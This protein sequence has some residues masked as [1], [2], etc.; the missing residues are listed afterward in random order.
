[1]IKKTVNGVTC[2]FADSIDEVPTEDD[3]NH[4]YINTKILP[5]GISV[6]D[7]DDII[8]R[9]RDYIRSFVDQ[10]LDGDRLIEYRFGIRFSD[11]T[12]VRIYGH[13]TISDIK[14]ELIDLLLKKLNSLN[15][16]EYQNSK[17]SYE[18]L[19][20]HI[21]KAVKTGDLME[22][23]GQIAERLMDRHD[24]EFANNEKNQ[25]EDLKEMV[26]DIIQS[27]A[28]ESLVLGS[29]N[30]VSNWK[31]SLSD[32]DSLEI[33]LYVNNIYNAKDNY[34]GLLK[35]Y[36]AVIAHEMFHY[37]HFCKTEI[38]SYEYYDHI[39]HIYFPWEFSQRKDYLSRVIEESFASYFEWL[40]CTKNNISNNVSWS[41]YEHSIT[42]YPYSGAKYIKDGHFIELINNSLALGMNDTLFEMINDIRKYYQII[43]HE[44][45]VHK[46]NI[47]NISN[48]TIVIK[49]KS[50][51]QL[52][53]EVFQLSLKGCRSTTY[54]YKGNII[55]FIRIDGKTRNGYKNEF[56][57][58]DIIETSTADHEPYKEKY[59]YIFQIVESSGDREYIYL[60]KYEY[61][62]DQSTQR[63]SFFKCLHDYGL[64]NSYLSSLNQEVQEETQWNS[65]TNDVLFNKNK[66]ISWITNVPVKNTTSFAEILEELQNKK[67][68][69]KYQVCKKCCIDKSQY[70]RL[71]GERLDS[72]ANPTKETVYKICIGLELNYEEAMYLI[73]K[74][75]F[76]NKDG[77]YQDML[78]EHCLKYSYYN[79]D[80]IDSS[81]IHANY[82]PL[83]N[84]DTLNDYI[85][86][87][88]NRKV[89]ITRERWGS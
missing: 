47:S 48:N 34:G 56:S 23:A 78:I 65:F 21:N 53:N 63:R 76:K 12:P 73:E 19:I 58:E 14:K 57:G 29:F 13:K 85:E 40:Y 42:I 45:I 35:A 54:N 28:F 71:L 82:K 64:I 11:E 37:Y 44:H 17:E 87:N 61:L 50:H 20:D 1:M 22:L 49:A 51:Y 27:C 6:S 36:E 18:N 8:K 5:K 25:Y 67:N 15:E 33:V 74:A 46:K 55:W 75:G 89:D 80:E 81:L 79:K 43:N 10:I 83:F 62:I 60:G 69:T 39:T 7:I 32:T 41:W 72:P 30:Y 70:N 84:T 4:F 16:E 31:G 59:R 68:L 88:K 24:D 9:V 26:E 66:S 2:I 38:R 86:K 77:D 3:D 52:L